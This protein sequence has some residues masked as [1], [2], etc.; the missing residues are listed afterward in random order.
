MDLVQHCLATTIAWLSDPYCWVLII[1][2]QLIYWT[3]PSIRPSLKTSLV[4]HVYGYGFMERNS[5]QWNLYP[6]FLAI[7][8]GLGTIGWC[9]Y[10]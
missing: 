8:Y 1:S 3:V 5:I 9:S 7:V 2:S 10:W 4:P 6:A